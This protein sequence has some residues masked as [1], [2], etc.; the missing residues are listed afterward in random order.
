MFYS[1]WACQFKT[2]EDS[3]DGTNN[4]VGSKSGVATQIQRKGT[5]CH[6]YSLLWTLSTVS[7]W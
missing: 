6:P 7:S 2:A 4:M 3:Y 5:P 1:E